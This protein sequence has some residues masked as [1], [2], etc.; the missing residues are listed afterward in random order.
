MKTLKKSI[1]AISAIALMAPAFTSCKKVSNGKLDGEWELTSG[2]IVDS[3]TQ[4]GS[5]TEKRVRT[6]T[7]TGTNRNDVDVINGVTQPSS[8]PTPFTKSLT[9]DKKSGTYTEVRVS[10]SEYVDFTTAINS[11]G[12]TKD[13]DVKITNV[14][15]ITITGIFSITGNTG[16]I[17]KNS[18]FILREGDYKSTYTRTYA[19]Y[20]GN[21]VFNVSGWK[22]YYTEASLPA[23]KSGNEEYKYKGVEGVVYTVED[24]KGEEMNISSHRHYEYSYGTTTYN[25]ETNEK[26]TFKKK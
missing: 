14:S 21:T 17:K 7:Y 15:T 2:T 26:L 12:D 13:L 18:Q 23:T 20:D 16:D 22:D 5:T 24:L 3:Y 19:Y 25:N 11:S 6:T 10:T 9:F 8:A 1:I 4:S